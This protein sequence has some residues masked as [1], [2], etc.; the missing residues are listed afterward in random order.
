[1]VTKRRTNGY[2]AASIEWDLVHMNGHRSLQTWRAAQDLLVVSYSIAKGLPVDERYGAGIQLR[3]A[4]WSVSCNIA[5][6]NAKRGRT[7][8]RRYLDVALGSLAEV[9][10]LIA[11]LSRLYHLEAA[12]RERV[13]T[14]R[15]QIT[16][17]IFGMLR[18]GR[19]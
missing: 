12:D 19:Q 4:A 8:R 6:G 15:R 14:L 7:E 10:S 3:R 18:R 1:M 13:E 5:E 17:G 11:G 9:D 16:A 2:S